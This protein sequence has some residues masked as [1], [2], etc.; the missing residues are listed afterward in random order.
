[1]WDQAIAHLKQARVLAPRS[2]LVAQRL[3]NILLWTRRYPEAME[4]TDDALRLAPTNLAVIELKAMTYLAQGDL[5]AARRV[6]A[7][8][9]AGLQRADLV[10]NF[11][12]YWDLMWLLDDQDRQLLLSLPVESFGGDAGSRALT[13]AQT[14]ALIPN[15]GEV[16][17]YAEEAQRAFGREAARNVGNEQLVIAHALALAYLGRRDE[18]VREGQRAIALAPRSRDAYAAPYIEHQLARIHLILGERDKALDLLEPLLGSPYYLSPAWL[19]I[20]PNLAPLKGHPR[21]EKLLRK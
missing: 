8:P 20:D 3:G 15:A 12:L 7:E 9:R 5:A 16:R 21:F 14:Y 6:V 10:M 11:A 17:R 18:A 4:A 13:C 1:M 19:A 2:V